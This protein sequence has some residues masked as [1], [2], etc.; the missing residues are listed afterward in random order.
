[1]STISPEDVKHLAELAKIKLS[2]EEAKHFAPQL[3]KIVHF[4]EQ[5]KEVNTKNIEETAQTTGLENVWRE[6]EIHPCEF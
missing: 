4:F 1:M 5:L 6:D 2:A 3:D